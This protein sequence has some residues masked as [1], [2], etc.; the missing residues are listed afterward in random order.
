[1]TNATVTSTPPTTISGRTGRRAAHPVILT[2][3][4]DVGLALHRRPLVVDNA[5]LA[6]AVAVRAVE[7]PEDGAHDAPIT[8]IAMSAIP[9]RRSI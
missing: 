2:D 3:E 1:V 6:I 7:A 9:M 4:R 5:V 8:P